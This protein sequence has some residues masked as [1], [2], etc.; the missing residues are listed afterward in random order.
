MYNGFHK[1]TKHNCFQLIILEMFLKQQISILEWFLKNHV[2]EDW[3]NN[4]ECSFAITR[5]NYILKCNFINILLY[6]YLLYFWSNK[7]C[8]CEFFKKKILVEHQIT[9]S[10]I[11]VLCQGYYWD[12]SHV[13]A[14]HL[15]LCFLHKTR[16]INEIIGRTGSNFD[17]LIKYQQLSLIM[18]SVSQSNLPVV[19]V[20]WAAAFAA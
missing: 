11:M 4:A 19:H 9:M 6:Y 13:P 1:N 18:P 15:W 20:K 14:L 7:C 5:I 3:S 10:R 8:L 2:T 16:L 12:E 17:R